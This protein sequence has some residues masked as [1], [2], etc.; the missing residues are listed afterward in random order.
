MVLSIIT[1]LIV[2]SILILVH[3]LGHFFAA[4]RAGVWVEEFGIGY[5]PRIYGKRL[6]ETLYSINLLPIGGFVKLHGENTEEGVSEKQR[7]FVY[8][9]KKKRI[10]IVVAGVLMNFLLAIAAFSVVYSI[11]GIPKNTENVRVIGVAVGSPAEQ[12]GFNIDDVVREA[13]G[14]RIVKTDQFAE[15]MK[16]KGGS[17]VVVAVERKNE[18]LVEISTTPRIDYPQEEG[19]LGVVITNFENYY[20]PFWQRPFL[21]IYYGFQEAFFWG[22]LVVG[23]FIEIF[24]NLLS[25]QAPQ[26]VAGPVGIYALTS[27]AASFGFSATINFLG[28]LSVNLAILNIIPFP[29]LDGGRL[30]FIG[31]ESVIG[32][33]VVPRVEAA[34]HTAGMIILLILIFAITFQDVK[35]LISAGS[36]S[37]FLES[38]LMQ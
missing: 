16:D 34:I 22:T 20:P 28:I 4:R 18:G 8:K 13:D 30:L 15:I 12:A 17:V 21:G 10:V 6:G 23:G 3:E 5:P 11:E 9:S 2:L 29:A 31:I 37:G 36:V 32:R 19:A 1:F 26:D 33:K 14:K 27:Q 38:V 35:R 25:G 7:A 24:R